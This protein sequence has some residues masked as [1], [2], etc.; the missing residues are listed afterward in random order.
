MKNINL[1]LLAYGN[2][3]QHNRAIFCILS[4]L[5]KTKNASKSYNIII[6]TDQAH[7]YEFLFEHIHLE[8]KLISARLMDELKGSDNYIHRIKIKIIESAIKNYPDVVI[9]LDTDTFFTKDPTNLFRKINNTTS[10]MH[11]NEGLIKDIIIDEKYARHKG[12]RHLSKNVSTKVSELI[13]LNSISWN[14]GVVGIHKDIS[15]KLEYAIEI[16][17]EV[18][19]STKIFTAEQIA[20]SLVL[21]KYTKVID[22][23]Q[24][25][26]HYWH[27]GRK[28]AIDQFLKDF[29]TNSFHE[30]SLD[31]KLL[32]VN[33]HLQGLSERIEMHPYYFEASALQALHRGD[34]FQSLKF[35]INRIIC[36]EAIR[37]N[38]YKDIFYAI[39]NNINNYS[40]K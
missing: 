2:H 10:I 16:C 38:F 8:I 40:T 19:N 9:F 3:V 1:I 27:A 23:I 26:Y 32:L 36:K 4:L 22:A 28:K 37:L 20:F 5:S 17:D 31:D 12:G 14:S 29:L 30:K 13:K 6:Y 34:F 7:H 33:K 15:D 24:C 21:D 35:I 39:K 25:V 18:Y 11:K